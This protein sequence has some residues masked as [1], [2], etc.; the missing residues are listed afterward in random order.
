MKRLLLVV[1]VLIGAAAIMTA[2]P[3]TNTNGNVNLTVTIGPN[4]DPYS[5]QVP[6]DPEPDDPRPEYYLSSI[7]WTSTFNIPGQSYHINYKALGVPMEK[8]K[9]LLYRGIDQ[10]TG[11]LVVGQHEG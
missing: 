11:K 3:A 6:Y 10:N 5:G 9:Y 8:G 1:M 4:F 7:T 2:L